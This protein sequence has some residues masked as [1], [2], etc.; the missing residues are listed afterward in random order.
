MHLRLEH[1]WTTAGA[2]IGRVTRGVA[3]AYAFVDLTEALE[4]ARAGDGRGA[5]TRAGAVGGRIAGATLGVSL[6]MVAGSVVA[7]PK[8]GGPVGALAGGTLGAEWGE[9]AGRETGRTLWYGIE[10]LTGSGPESPAEG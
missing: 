10:A 5:T 2:L 4:C 1:P 9:A 6:G 3:Y 7:T 8:V